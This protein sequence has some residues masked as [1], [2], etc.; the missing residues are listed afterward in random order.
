M[1]SGL[2]TYNSFSPSQLIDID[3]NNDISVNLTDI[4]LN[5][6]SSDLLSLD[7]SIKCVLEARP[8]TPAAAHLDQSDSLFP[9]I[10][11]CLVNFSVDILQVSFDG[12]VNHLTGLGVNKLA[13]LTHDLTM[14]IH[15]RRAPHRLDVV[16]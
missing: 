8:V 3:I 10:S 12:A 5:V 2:Q 11:C 9:Q 1:F 6:L 4:N 16:L 7:L 15:W 13:E 14:L